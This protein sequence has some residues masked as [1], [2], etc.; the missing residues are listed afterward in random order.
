MARLG[1]IQFLLPSLCAGVLFSGTILF[2]YIYLRSKVKL[3]LSMTVL[4]F[5]GFIFVSSEAMILASGAWLYQAG[6]AIQFHRI[7]QL[8]VTFF[9]FG[10]PFLMANLL[11]LNPTLK[12][13][14][15]FLII[16]GIM[17]SFITLVI[18]FVFPDLFV[19]ISNPNDSW[20][21][22]EGA[23]G[24]GKT[25]ILYFIRD[26]YLAF[27]GLYCIIMMF[28]DLIV[29]KNYKYIPFSLLGGLLAG[30]A[31]ID[32]ILG[33]YQKIHIGFFSDI[34]YSRFSL[35]VTLFI[36]FCMASLT[37]MFI[38]QAKMVEKTNRALKNAEN[39]LVYLAYNDSLTGLPNRKSFYNKFQETLSIAERYSASE[40]LRGLLFVDLNNFKE[41]ND[42][43]GHNVGDKLLIEVSARLK[44]SL[45][46]SDYVF[47]F[48]GDEFAIII[49]KI[50]SENDIS[51]VC[52]KVIDSVF[53]PYFI[54]AHE[55]FL[56]S[57]VGVSVYPKDGMDVD[58]LIKN[59][60]TAL[61]EAK[62]ENNRFVFYDKNLNSI[63]MRRLNIEKNLRK[64]IERNELFLNYQP[65]VDRKGRII[66]AEALLRWENSEVGLITPMEFVP[67]AEDS[68]LI[69]PIGDWVLNTA[70]NQI[71][72]WNEI[73]L[74][75]MKVAIN[76]STKQ[77]KQP[78]FVEKMEILQSEMPYNSHQIEIEITESCMMEDPETTIDKMIH[79]SKK[80]IK[81]AIDDFG[82][83]YSSLSYLKKLP[84][85]KVKID[86]SFVRD[87]MTD[88]DNREITKAI[89]AMAHNLRKRVLAE[90]VET[91][92]QMDFLISHSCDEM[93]GYFFSKPVSP[94][95]IRDLIIKYS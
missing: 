38:D 59:A 65:I 51:K 11:K 56:G 72:K 46:K 40:K 95:K 67:I 87:M 50:S 37:R 45:R 73:G 63:T 85:E 68:G 13:I 5:L 54:D 31:A 28:V 70:K 48:G 32:D 25:G 17:F 84:I 9:L 26:C 62:K 61:F 76:V 80:G 27:V 49:N 30:Y 57:S 55:I 89:I 3:H 71:L 82:T 44:N 22:D 92:E 86:Q 93:Q 8:S 39:E 24:R 36:L 15:K 1:L 16:A 2:L 91:R 33:S 58:D 41:V 43:L 20:F 83:G 81:I 4:G 47:R 75:G 23:F 12:K 6:I 21:S 53:F 64:A 14:N 7:Q 60:D 66:E 77:F 34:Y 19:S 79:L 78:D 10:L 18:S 42:T 35:G 52:Q 94:E 69:I 74:S 88:I 90:G 29:F